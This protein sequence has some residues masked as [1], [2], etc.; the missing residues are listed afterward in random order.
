MIQSSQIILSKYGTLRMATTKQADNSNSNPIIIDPR[1]LGNYYDHDDEISLVDLWLSLVKQK[2]VFFTTT[3]IIILFTLVY[4]L[5]VPES[6][7][8]KTDIAI[9]TQAQPKPKPKP[10]LFNHQKQLLPTLIMQ[11]FRNY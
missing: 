8:Y 7:T 10:N 3:S 1:M 2:K 4:I 9:G 5:L 6:Y 11:L